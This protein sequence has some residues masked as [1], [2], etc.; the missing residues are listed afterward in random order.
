[1]A[2]LVPS[3]EAQAS[4]A[5]EPFLCSLH[6]ALR[7][8]FERRFPAGPTLPQAH[9]WPQIARGKDTLIAA[10]T[11]SGK[12]LS[13]FLVCLDRLYKL[14]DRG[15]LDREKAPEAA[16]QVVYV[17]PL[18]A[19]TVD[20]H[21]NLEVPL[22][23]IAETAR[24]L[25]LPVPALRVAA[26]SGD[27]P[28]K[29]RARMVKHPPHILITT[30][31]SLYL[32]VTA[33]KTREL[34]GRVQ[35]VIVDEIHAVAKDKRGAHLA[36]TLERLSHLCASPP[37]RIGLSA[38]QRPVERVARLLVGTE[39][40]AAE[41]AIVDVGHRRELDLA[42]ELPDSELEAVT[43]HEQM[44]EVL[45][46][47]TAHIQQRRT[48]LIFVNTRRLSERL[49][50]LLAERLGADQVAAH[51]GSLSKDR[52]LAIEDRLRRG[53]LRALVAT[54]SLELG[55]DIG[56][57]E[58][59]CQ[60]GSPR[61]IATFLQRVGRSG[62][63]RFGTPVG[64]LYPLTRD[65]LI[66]CMALMRAL[67]AGRLDQLRPP[68]CPLDILAQQI[69]AECAA[70]D[71]DEA[72]L[73]EL[74]RQAA[75]FATLTRQAYQSIV[76]LVSEGVTTGRGRRAAYVKRDTI[77]GTL[78]GR[79]GARLAAIT[80]GG[81]IPDNADYRVVADPD[82]SFVGTINEDFAIESMAGDV[83]LL[84]ST[85]WRIRRVERGVVRVVDAQGASPS[86]PFWLGEAPARTFELSEEVSL[87]REFV[88]ASFERLRD[89]AQPSSSQAL[90]EQLTGECGV[91]DVVA[92]S[93]VQYLAASYDALGLL[94][95]QR[96]LI[97]ERFFDESGG[98][99]LVVHSP[100]GGR[101]NRGL[102]LLLRKRFCRSFDFELQAAANDD[103]ILLSLG[104]QH[105]FPLEELTL[106][107]SSKRLKE[108][109]TQAVLPTP[110]FAV[111]WRWNL[112]RFL[113][114]LRFRG[115]KKNPPQLQRMEADDLMAAIFPS[116]AACQ[117]NATG[118]RV[119]P[120]HPVV[121]QTLLDCMTE[122]MD[123]DGLRDVLDR[124]ASGEIR[125][126]C[127]DTTEPSPLSHEILNSRPYTFLD[128]APL[129][130]RR[131]RAV[132]LRRGLPVS[133]RALAALDPVAIDRVREEARPAPRDADELHDL[134]LATLLWPAASSTADFFAALQSGG[135]AHQATTTRGVFWC[136]AE[137]V[138][139]VLLLE[140]N[141]AL[142]PSTHGDSTDGSASSD[143]DSIAA[144]M[145]RGH[146]E[147][148]GPESI[149]E[150]TGRLGLEEGLTRAALVLLE[151][152][153]SALRGH[154]D[155]RIEG[156]QICS[157]RLLTR[158][159]AYTRE[160]QRR[161]I[162]PVTARDLMRFLL[163]W[164]HATGTTQLD[165]PGGLLQVIAQLQGFETAVGA[166]EKELFKIRIEGYHG[167][168]LDQL[169]HSGEVAWGR[170]SVRHL[171]SI[172]G[173]SLSRKT[174]VTVALR[175]DLE[176]LLHAVRGG[177]K[178][179]LAS[180]GELPRVLEAIG[181]RGAMFLDD[182]VRETGLVQA[183]VWDALWDGVARGT[184]TAD[185]F[186]ALRRLDRPR[187]FHEQRARVG[188]RGL[189]QG[190]RGLVDR[191]GRWAL[192]GDRGEPQG[193]GHEALQPGSERYDELCEAIAEQLLARYGVVFRDL[194]ARESFTVPWRDIVWALRRLEARGVIRGG[195]FVTGFV[196][197]QYAL[198]EAVDELRKV[199]RRERTGQ[200]VRVSAADPLNLVG[201][202]TPGPRLAPHRGRW[203]TF[204]DGA[205]IE[206]EPRFEP[207]LESG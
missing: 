205:V 13:G 68:V 32:L 122:A 43:S 84:G 77:H 74:F 124:V 191:E 3:A 167:G 163:E 171:Q 169:S 42:V 72:A 10:P 186:H 110:M 107:L 93:A 146:L 26:R 64:K 94:P 188:R 181:R 117:D 45:D 148:L 108:A 95:T 193:S 155:P 48:T 69:I 41:C 51:H 204:E 189:R 1:M 133:S 198:P 22:A 159:H 177:T 71:W 153:G 39:R 79:R 46:K 103:A 183:Q 165:G 173:A 101:V 129:E 12:T 104:P 112:N 62:H 28:A 135:R 8:W 143:L 150:L 106:M 61:S 54:A 138:K 118:P 174:P 63:S 170:L 92:R 158:I 115:G 56:P 206:E 23:E 16:V 156:P 67:R 162:E 11:G 65:E 14:A 132:Q 91:D 20:I 131:A 59:V 195:R 201:I 144:G 66:E 97:F 15:L 55:I 89:T 202:L 152:E 40:R 142:Q 187:R 52:R 76:E 207:A 111:R 6:P 179:T 82:D 109:M 175:A 80:S 121:N 160:S 182:I 47:I 73:Y 197:E 102:G 149:S 100:F 75:P 7:L 85:S 130:E 194:M 50:H 145:L 57:V 18:K 30:P 105:S 136:A 147:G 119:V 29:D 33:E 58:L 60:I 127:R 134:L 200:L 123:I 37:Q 137:R 83:F 157:R 19:L 178:P 161:A 98:M 113:L 114:V 9:A 99:Q 4:A 140:P 196:G 180:S 5:A 17:S 87:L 88:E 125:V 36:L 168:L 184:L 192:F 128:D 2:R 49:A 27:T 81:A 90:L 24:E 139:D 172:R 44:A 141:A 34:L 151:R 35:T 96:E 70:E 203:V 116:L 185:G 120:D 53:D 126:H 190:A 25:G 31:E 154:F 176:W 86:I 38:T 164:Q 166:W 199:R 21:K 78:K